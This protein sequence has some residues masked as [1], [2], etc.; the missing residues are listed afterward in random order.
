MVMPAL[1]P[2]DWL[3]ILD[4]D[5][6]LAGIRADMPGVSFRDT[7]PA[8]V[9][10][11]AV[12]SMIYN[13]ILL[14]NVACVQ[15]LPQYAQDS[16]LDA[17]GASRELP[18]FEGEL[19][20]PYRYRI[21]NVVHTWTRI[22]GNEGL[23]IDA[24]AAAPMSIA[25]VAIVKNFSAGSASVYALATRAASQA[26]AAVG[27]PSSTLL[28]AMRAYITADD[29]SDEF[30]SLLTPAP[31]IRSYSV[32]AS[33]GY[34]PSASEEEVRSALIAAAAAF[35][36]DFRLLGGDVRHTRFTAAMYAAHAAVQSVSLTQFQAADYDGTNP[37]GAAVGDLFATTDRAAPG[38]A[39][40]R[41]LSIAY[42]MREPIALTLTAAT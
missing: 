13:L 37:V 17:W 41:A 21:F 39:N 23:E 11:E 38:S 18:R 35:S 26:G 4:R 6:I 24:R 25:D 29:R 31:T 32:A 22:Q 7:D 3:P 34:A 14:F 27:T 9:E 8:A 33:V 28:D 36:D 2:P 5:D 1:P 42:S 12:A 30:F 40:P 10:T 16:A 15:A 20:P 19:D